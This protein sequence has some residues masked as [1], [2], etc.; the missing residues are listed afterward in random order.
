MLLQI[1]GHAEGLDLL[2]SK[3]GSHRGVG[4]EPLFVL[5]VLQILL[6]QVGPKSLDT[7][8]NNKIKLGNAE[9]FIDLP[10]DVKF[11]HPSWSR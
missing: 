10:E 11:F 3:D 5:G 9:I 8:R 2:V 1:L 6:L 7:L 4:G